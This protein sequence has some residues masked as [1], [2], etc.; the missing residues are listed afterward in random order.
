MSV[1]IDLIRGSDT[2]RVSG[3]DPYS[4]I[5]LTG[6][7]LP[8]VRRQHERGPQQHGSTD[9]G[10]LL[11]ERM[12]NLALLI[13]GGTYTL[14]Q[15]DDYRDELADFLK[16]ME[17]TPLKLRLTR[18]NGTIRQIDTNVVGMVDFPNTLQ[19][20]IGPSQLVVVQFEA[21]DPIPYEP[22]LNSVVFGTINGAYMVPMD[23]PLLYFAGTTID[24]TVSVTYAGKWEVFPIISVIGPADDLIITNETTGKVLDFSGHNIAVGD[25]YTI[26]LRYGF[27]RITD[28]NGNLKNAA[29]TDDS[30]LVDFS[31]VP[32]PTAPGGVNDI[33]VVAGDGATSDT[34]VAMSY[35]DRYPSMG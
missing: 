22:T 17:A 15:L 9:V 34:E 12:L 30:D 13:G 27:K 29:L 32:S 11:D 16:P 31:L 4:F 3:R 18:D 19:E 33:H 23:I 24:A 10:F 25:I 2:L 20:R 26:D 14:E 28:Q 35:Y 7:G 6:L 5:S 8:P 21:A 1:T